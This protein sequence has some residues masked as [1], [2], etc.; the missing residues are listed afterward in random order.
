LKNRGKFMEEKS[1]LPEDYLPFSKI[2]ICS[3]WFIGGEYLIEVD[4]NIPLLIGKGVL[5]LVWLSVPVSKD[6][7]EYIVERNISRNP[8]IVVDLS[9]DNKS[10]IIKI[11]QAKFLRDKII[12]NIV[13]DSDDSITIKELDMRPIGLIIYGDENK[14]NIGT[15]IIQNSTVAATRTMISIGHNN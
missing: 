12:L 6:K 3:N 7:W 1:K 14:L 9:K 15:N 2:K 11:T 4:K 8:T 10:V 5:P 13:M